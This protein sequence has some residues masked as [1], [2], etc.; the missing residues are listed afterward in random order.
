MQY[1]LI[2]NNKENVLLS[3][4]RPTMAAASLQRLLY[5]VM[6]HHLYSGAFFF[7]L[8]LANAFWEFFSSPARLEGIKETMKN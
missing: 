5:I 6:T 4:F 1:G 3:P 7:F 2:K 8:C